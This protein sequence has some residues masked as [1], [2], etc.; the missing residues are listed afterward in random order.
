MR[1][2]DPLEVGDIARLRPLSNGAIE[3]VEACSQ[4]GRDPARRLR[5][6]RFDEDILRL[7]GISREFQ[8]DVT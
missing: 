3:L 6:M 5:A 4:L 1:C 2:H 7:T 8:P